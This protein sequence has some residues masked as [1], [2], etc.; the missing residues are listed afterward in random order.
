M[1]R[2][3]GVALSAL[4]RVM[5]NPDIRR[6]LA[7][8]MLGWASEWAWL[9][10]LWVYA[11]NESGVVAVGV[12]GLA[13]T[14]PAALLAPALST[15][16]DRLPRHRVLLG[17]HIGR[18]VTVGLVAVAVTAGW[19]LVVYLLAP[20]DALFGVL[21]RPTHAPLLPALARSPEE[22]V[23]SNVASSTFEGI[24]TLIGPIVGGLLIAYAAPVWGFV[25]AAS[26]F[27]LA[28]FSISGVR[29][30]QALRFHPDRPDLLHTRFGGLRALRDYPS[31]GLVVGLFTSQVVVRGLLNVLVVIAVVDLLRIGQEGVGYLNSAI[32]AGGLIGA[33]A[34]VSLV[35]RTR[36]APSFTAGLVLWGTPILLI[37]LIPVAGPAVVF[38]AILGLGNAVLDVSGFT[39]LQRT[40]PNAVRGRV[41]GV[42]EAAVMLG[43][44]FGS[45][46]A[47][48]LVL[49][50]GSRGALIVTGALLPVL[51]VVT[52][53]W[54]SRA[55][56]RGVI[57]GRQLALLRG[58]PML[59]PLPMTVLEQVAGDLVA[60]RY[61]D[62]ALII[63]QGDVGD[64]FYILAEGKAT[65]T[66]DGRVVQRF[67]PGD[68]FGEI[69]LLRDVPRTASVTAVG[70]VLAYALDR[71]AFLAAVS[72]DRQSRSAADAVVE[73]R[74]SQPA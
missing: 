38:L 58:V 33:L 4:R 48:P 30:A 9:V 36:M 22:L 31:A 34:A 42:L 69:A 55:D 50:V 41:F 24:G 49:V 16:T 19:P 70:P 60:V 35:G 73:A 3:L 74:L 67:G 44:G 29:P 13:R 71:D 10:A 59:A 57:P 8:W 47:P 56:E 20:I 46:L 25:V 28:A 62:D 21:H 43:T 6:A 40:V 14:L 52:W 51:A 2:S 1:I 32:G 39:L 12:L 5:A 61:A 23:A 26:G 15:I 7:A 18:A 68:W 53:R 37:G 27:A 65:V 64:R 54:V 17:V 63:H 45:V 11:Y 66:I 72:G